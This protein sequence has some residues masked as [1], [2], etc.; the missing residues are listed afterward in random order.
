MTR[1]QV[2]AIRDQASRSLRHS[3][4]RRALACAAIGVAALLAGCRQDMQNQ[5]KLIPQ[6]GSTIFADHRG[7]RPQVLNTVA[8]GQLDEESYFY[9]GVVQGANGYRME[10]DL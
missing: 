5:P 4:A 9:T 6:R 1:I 8:R 2:S 10:E 3:V 7:A